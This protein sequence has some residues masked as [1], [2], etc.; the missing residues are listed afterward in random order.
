MSGSLRVARVHFPVT[1]LGPGSRLGLWVQGCAL[2]CPGCMSRDTWDR[3]GG[4]VMMIDD[5]VAKC[6]AALAR[7]ADGITVSGGEPLDQAPG[8]AGLLRRVRQLTVAKPADVLVYT[9]YEL[10][11]ARRRSPEVLALVDA[12]ITGRYEVAQPTSL[13]WRGSA[14]QRLVPLTGLGRERYLEYVRAETARPAIQIGSDSGSHWLIG[15]PRR[16]DLQRLE[17][18]LGHRGLT[19][20]GV[21]WRPSRTGRKL[22]EE[23]R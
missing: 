6:R 16:G 2:A 18:E 22:G 3:T 8:L 21:S 9:G 7:G 4:T 17:K 13:I 11:E 10:A 15:V 20:S 14:N 1:A 23:S 5:L 19:L 12:V